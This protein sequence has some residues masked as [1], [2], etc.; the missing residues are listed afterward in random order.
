MFSLQEEGKMRKHL[1]FAAAIITPVFFI[2]CA[3]AGESSISVPIAVEGRYTITTNIADDYGVASAVVP[4]TANKGDKV[5]FTVTPPPPAI[6]EA[7]GGGESLTSL[8]RMASL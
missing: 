1:F 3:D 6:I 8:T 5:T 7:G 4:T 2:A